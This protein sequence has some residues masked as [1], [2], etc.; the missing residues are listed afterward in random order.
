MT[1]ARKVVRSCSLLLLLLA[2]PACWAATGNQLS[3]ASDQEAD[4]PSGAGDR[5]LPRGSSEDRPRPRSEE[6][7]LLDS[8]TEQ[9]GFLRPRLLRSNL[10][11]GGL[12]Q[13]HLVL[14]PLARDLCG[15]V[16]VLLC[17]AL[18]CRE[19]AG[20]LLAELIDDMGID[21]T[22]SLLAVV[23]ASVAER[24]GSPPAARHWAAGARSQPRSR[25]LGARLNVEQVTGCLLEM[26]GERSGTGAGPCFGIRYAD[27]SSLR[28][29]A[30]SAHGTREAAEAECRELGSACA[31]LRQ[32]RPGSFA[33]VGRGGSY[34]LARRAGEGGSWIHDCAGG[35]PPRRRPGR[36]SSERR[37]A[38]YE[39][40]GFQGESAV[41]PESVG[42]V[43]EGWNGSIS[44][45]KVEACDGC[46]IT[47]CTGAGFTGTCTNLDNPTQ[48]LGAPWDNTIS[49]LKVS[50][51]CSI[52]VEKQ[53]YQTVE[54]IPYISY[55]YNLAT[56]IYY[57]SVNCYWE[58]GERVESIIQELGPDLANSLTGS[59]AQDALSTIQQLHASGGHA[60]TETVKEG[61][62]AAVQSAVEDASAL[63]GLGG[64]RGGGDPEG[65]RRKCQEGAGREGR[66]PH[67]PGGKH[68]LG[69]HH[70]RKQQPQHE[71]SGHRG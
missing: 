51:Q 7:L 3:P 58:A 2:E 48:N 5:L 61:L 56:S 66:P 11:C 33:V 45:L 57:Y 21:L 38:V 20:S 46:I 30:L 35:P 19:R 39:L 4:G 59:V 25:S 67:G 22:A 47:V 24:P 49:S 27:G 52:E 40:P 23:G 64:C 62:Q 26:A 13:F 55:F 8:V 16:M 60:G 29:E 18:G 42:S 65:R 68:G 53:I 31:G 14:P 10:S 17:G 1:L 41:L 37:V 69:L 9:A 44:S 12:A 36:R 15:L 63:P 32:R 28:G 34:A 6:E 71:H 43:G 70:G 50:S 54:Y